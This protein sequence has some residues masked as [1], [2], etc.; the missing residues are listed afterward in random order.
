[1]N[2]ELE[3]T[4][5]FSCVLD[6]PDGAPWI[7]NYDVRLLMSTVTQDMSEYNVAYQRIKHWFLFVMQ[8]AVLLETASPRAT[9]WRDSGM[10]C[11]DFPVYPIDQV[12][13]LMLMRKLGAITEGRIDILQIAVSSPADDWVHYLCD[14]SDDLHWFETPGWWSDPRPISATGK[15]KGRTS[16]KV[17]SIS[18]TND[19]KDHDLDWHS[20]GSSSGNVSV[21]PGKD[22]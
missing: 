16:G 19:W 2:V 20:S 12:V 3:K 9:A 21:L 5:S 22:E 10:R 4:F 13:G 1:M 11:M 7:N 15:H 8:D 17:I 14:Q 6:D 18:R